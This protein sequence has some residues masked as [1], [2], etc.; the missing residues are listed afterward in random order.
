[1]KKTILSLFIVC[2]I[3]SLAID[4]NDNTPYSVKKGDTLWDISEHFLNNPFEWK[5]IWK[6][7]PQIKNPDLIYPDDLIV[8]RYD[9]N[10]NPYLEKKKE[11]IVKSID[12][13]DSK[14]IA[15]IRQIDDAIPAVDYSKIKDFNNKLF[16]SNKII[17]D[18]II[19]LN[20]ENLIARKGDTGYAL[21]DDAYIGE[22]YYILKEDQRL[23]EEN[24]NIYEIIGEIKINGKN[25]KLYKFEILN[26]D[27]EVKENFNL[28]SEQDLII[29]ESKIYP[30]KPNQ[31][32]QDSK[33]IYVYNKI[34]GFNG[35][36]V[37]I[38]KGS[39]NNVEVG[40]LFKIVSKDK[41]IK[42]GDEKYKLD[43]EEKSLL[44]IY[45]VDDNFSYGLI[46]NNKE[47]IK[48]NDSIKNPF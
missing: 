48:V 7:N 47:L 1:M 19:N 5:E 29:N 15:H 45:K 17:K 10:G 14:P 31:I 40:N 12:L 18:K 9:S 16:A 3:N 33:V 13:S 39:D 4:I 6:K 35:D 8:L 24:V 38:N 21:L 28:I 27:N 2:S 34:N 44:F 42:S 32:D 37:I 11:T 46:L 22:K 30:S 23:K 20:K 43:G 41:I 25:N 26:A 36:I